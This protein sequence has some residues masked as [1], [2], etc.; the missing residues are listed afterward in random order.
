M[1][2]D[3]CPKTAAPEVEAAWL[4][5]HMASSSDTSSASLGLY[6]W[7]ATYGRPDGR[8]TDASPDEWA[9]HY[10]SGFASYISKNITPVPPGYGLHLAFLA[11]WADQ[12]YTTIVVGERYAAALMATSVSAEA[13]QGIRSPWSAFVI[14]VPAG[15]L[16]Q[17]DRIRVGAFDL[18]E[19][20]A[21]EP[22]GRARVVA[23]STVTG[24]ALMQ[25]TST[26]EECLADP[27]D[28][29]VDG[30]APIE[31]LDGRVL[32]MAQ[33][34]AAGCILAAL[35]PGEAIERVHGGGKKKRRTDAPSHR[36]VMVGRPISLDVRP[37]ILDYIAG[38][39]GGAPAVQSLVRGHY[40]RQACGP[41]LSER[42]T[43]WIEPYW[44]GPD[45]APVLGKMHSLDD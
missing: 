28:S 9:H 35:R 27:V 25:S 22:V 14:Q 36:V 12:A 20:Y 39:T 19:S 7:E 5:K 32:A 40:K 17:Y 4:R 26:L 6:C 3:M 43:I 8:P 1:K 41:Q 2:F 11:K 38:R 15:L 24:E 33:R 30:F 23:H 16:A 37:A 45:D 29:L 10:G 18:K 42:R 44:R 21:E 34:L 31:G 13:L